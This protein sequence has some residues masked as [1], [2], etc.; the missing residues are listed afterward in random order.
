MTDRADIVASYEAGRFPQLLVERVRRHHSDEIGR[1]FRSHLV[2]LHNSGTIDVLEV[3]RSIGQSPIS[4]SDFFSVQS[5]FVSLIP[6]LEAP[7]LAMLAAVKGLVARGGDDGAASWPNSAFRRW[8]EIGSRAHATLAAINQD[9]PNDAAYL[10]LSLQAL[11]KNEPEAALDRAIALLA[12]SSPPAQSAAANA[13][14]TLPLITDEARSRAANA[15]EVARA[16]CADDNL[17]GHILTAISEIART[18]SEWES[19]ASAMIAASECDAE[20]L[21]IYQVSLELMFHGK[22]LPPSIVAGLSAIARKVQVQSTGTM[23]NIDHAASSLIRAGRIDEGLALITP[24][25][26]THEALTSLEMLD[27]TSHALLELSGDR[28]AHVVVNWLLAFDTNLGL[29][30]L[31]LVGKHHGSPLVLDFDAGSLA[32]SDENALLLAHRTIGYLF[33]HP[34]TAASIVLALIRLVGPEARQVMADILFDPLLINYSGEFAQWLR[35]KSK[36]EGDPGRSVAV[37]LLARLEAYIK[38]LNKVGR[39]KELRP[40]E[41]EML[42]EANRQHESMRQLHKEVEKRSILMSIVSRSVLLYG[43]RSISYFDLNGDKQRH[44]MKLHKMSHSIEAPRLDILEPFEL[45]YR[46]RVFRA[47]R[48]KP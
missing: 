36:E 12:N 33:I 10:F 23:N 21:A 46:L 2:E 47:M 44:E 34:I 15:L 7:A 13:I 40:S 38:G 17:L 14:G 18:A 9:D 30:V 29:A 20:D 37:S 27:S 5:T 25:I 26:S 28:L 8:A 1:E 43:N 19:S 3:A 24:L 35:V 45:D 32:L 31:K 48:A 41:R 11:A 16:T 42:I 22:D 4:Q 39:I 6:E